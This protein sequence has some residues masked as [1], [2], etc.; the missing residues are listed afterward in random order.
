MIESKQPTGQGTRDE[1]D[2]IDRIEAIYTDHG[3]MRAALA[4]FRHALDALE[5]RDDF[6]DI[7]PFRQTLDYELSTHIPREERLIEE[8]LGADHPAL[9]A[10]KSEH[11][12][13]AE[14]VEQV[15]TLIDNANDEVFV[16]RQALLQSSRA[17]AKH[18]REHLEREEAHALPLLMKAALEQR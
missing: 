12:P 10:L 1:G 8:L 3:R 9:E 4:R 2:A 16:D 18:L 7:Y 6:G 17:L 14:A 11:G 15:M 5:H 13:L